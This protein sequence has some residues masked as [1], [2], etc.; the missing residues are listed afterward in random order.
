MQKPPNRLI[1]K[2]REPVTVAIFT[3]VLVTAVLAFALFAIWAGDVGA[4]PPHHDAAAVDQNVAA[5]IELREPRLVALGEL[6]DV[7][8]VGRKLGPGA[9]LPQP[10]RLR[11]LELRLKIGAERPA[12]GHPVPGQ[13]HPER[14]DEQP[15]R[16]EETRSFGHDVAVLA[17]V[18]PTVGT[19]GHLPQVG[20]VDEEHVRSSPRAAVRQGWGMVPEDRKRFGGMLTQ[21]IRD[22][23]SLS[24]LKQVANRWGFIDERKEEA[25]VN[26]LVDKLRIKLEHIHRPLSTLSGGNQQKVV[27]AKWLNLE[28]N[29]LLIDEP[30]RGVDVGARAEIYQ[31]IQD[32]ANQ[33]IYIVMVSSD[34]EELMGMA[35]RILVMQNGTIQGH[36]SR[37]DFSEEKI[38]RLAIGAD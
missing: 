36:L 6:D 9:T 25:V 20:R 26:N 17:G 18:D 34:M 12:H 10:D 19:R 33:G 4:A 21:S 28:L 5:T 1:A 22:N 38:L 7:I 13:Q 14:G 37:P 2:L 29:V 24:N 15:G 3:A 8:L 32:L 35:D 31:I 11:L 16:E 27:L 30:T 23:I